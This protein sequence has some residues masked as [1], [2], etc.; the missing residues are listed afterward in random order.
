MKKFAVLISLVFAAASPLAAQTQRTVATPSSTTSAALQ[1]AAVAN[2]N[3]TVADLSGYSVALV[4]TFCSGCTGGSRIWFEGSPDGTNFGPLISNK[5]GDSTYLLAWTTVSD[6]YTFFQVP[7]YSMRYLRARVSNYSTGTL[8]ATAYASMA[9]PQLTNTG[10]TISSGNVT[11]ILS[12]DAFLGTPVPLVGQLAAGSDGT[13]AIALRTNG[14]GRLQVDVITAPT[15]A[16]TGTFWQATQPVSAASLPLPSGASTSANQ[17]TEITALQLIDNL[18]NTIGSTTSGQS[19]ALAMGATTTAAPTYTTGQT[20]P[21]SLTTAGGLRVDGSGATQPVSGTVTANAGTGT[22]AVS[23]ASLPLPTGAATAA[24]QPALGTAGASSTDVISVQGIASGT[25]LPISGS[26]SC[27]NCSGT[28]VSVN[29]DVASANADPGTPAYGVRQDTPTG[30]TST[31]G[32]YGPLKLD[33]I[34]RLWVNCGTGCSGGTQYTHDAALT[35]GSSA[36]TLSGARASAAAPT[37]VSADDDAVALWALRSGALAVQPTFAGVLGV[38]GNGVSGTGVQRVT[39]A[40]D[41]TGVVAAT[42]SGAWTVTANA[43]TNLN[44]STLALE[45]GGNLAAIKADVDK[46]PSQGQALAAASLPVVLT[47]AQ[48][49]TLTPPAAITG[50]ALDATLTGG[51][52]QSK[53]TDGTNVS[54]VKAAST[55]P[56]A[57]DKALVTT[58]RDAIPAGTNVIGHVIADSGSTTAVTGTVSTNVAQLAGTTT[59]TNSGSKSAGTL[60]VVL[61]TDQPQLTNKI[62][63]TPDANSA[64]N[65]A[66]MNGAALASPD[67]NSYA[68]SPNAATATAA[69]ASSACNILSAASTNATNCKG[70]AGNLYGY[71]IYNTSTTVYYLRLY[72]LSASPTC[73]SATGF[74]RTIP[75]PPAAAAGGV[76]GAVSNYTVPVNF[77]TGIG[78][79]ITGGSASTDNTNAATGVFGEIRYK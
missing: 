72:N 34:G 50:F 49:T 76:G 61:A 19:G 16:V 65:V 7:L 45:T 15:T 2:G 37:N 71:E 12:S 53:I 32:D 3:G 62:L 59:D 43:G 14:T 21:L 30:T 66:Q 70:S 77:G 60:R 9:T 20:N 68:I 41:S 51:T 55:L 11:A 4:S 38:A 40:S 27:S 74:I 24:K 23:A 18:P 10:T 22:F 57:T 47:A 39:I 73:S 35:I 78:F 31:D 75:I 5:V 8:S 44:T 64:V 54:T 25:A 26:I 36:T 46:I 69:A 6:G 52:Q 33:S 48:I 67:A 13:N 17:S 56:V 1:T 28:G 63:V 79:C 42:Q 58:Q 29:E